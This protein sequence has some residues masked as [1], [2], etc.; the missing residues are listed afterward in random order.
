MSR[1][2]IVSG[3]SSG[4]GVMTVRELALAETVRSRDAAPRLLDQHEDGPP[5]GSASACFRRLR[6]AAPSC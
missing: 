4:F 3:A 2:V 5:R 1:V 6:R